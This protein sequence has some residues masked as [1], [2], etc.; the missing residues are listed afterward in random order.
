MPDVRRSRVAEGYGRIRL[1]AGKKRGDGLAD[2]VASSD[3]DGVLAA[4]VHSREL[5]QL[6]YA[7][8]RAREETF[9]ADHH[10]ADVDWRK[11]VNVLLWR[12]R[13]DDRLVAYVLRN[14]QLHEDAV[15][16]GVAIELPHER[17]KLVLGRLGGK[18]NLA[19]EHPRLG[20]CLSLRG[21]VAHARGIVADENNGEPGRHALLR[22]QRG[23]S[24]RDFGAQAARK[25]L[26]VYPHRHCMS[27]L[28][29]TGS[30]SHS[31]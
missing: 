13:V 10:L 31:T 15:Y 22:L 27:F 11:A 23:D 12:N 1:L 14:G 8:G 6:D 7:V 26:S 9:F 18:P 29:P 20:A 3:H 19:R 28:S 16:L 24:G 17:D 30:S 25:F 21:N 4:N 5:Y 2:D